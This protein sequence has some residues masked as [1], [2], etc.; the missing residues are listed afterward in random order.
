MAS[1]IR[2]ALGASIY[3][4]W[5]ERNRRIFYQKSS[6]KKKIL[7]DI[8]VT[9]KQQL[10][11]LGLEDTPSV[12]ATKF[13]EIFGLHI[14]QNSTSIKT[15][16]LLPSSG[17]MIRLNSGA[18][19]A[20]DKAAIGGIIRDGNKSIISAFSID[21]APSNINALEIEAIIRGSS[22]AMQKGANMLWIESDSLQA[23]NIIK[24]ICKCPWRQKF[25]IPNL[26]LKL[27]SLISW[28]ISHIWREA[29]GEADYLS[30]PDCPIKGESLLAVDLPL[31]LINIINTDPLG[32]P[33]QR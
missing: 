9:I 22:L 16:D 20:G 2:I 7:S 30:K 12:K 13:A 27:N 31:E 5:A 8:L 1:A 17:D 29:N 3:H 33:Y 19:L 25:K 14:S 26:L 4:L 11:H 6:H 10:I 24:G 28:E 21:S 15:C 32:V 18:S 23:V